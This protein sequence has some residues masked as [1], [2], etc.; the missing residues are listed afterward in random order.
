LLAEYN[1]EKQV[2]M[3]NLRTGNFKLGQQVGYSDSYHE[4]VHHRVHSI[5]KTKIEPQLAFY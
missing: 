3:A 2:V 1:P 5:L 4:K